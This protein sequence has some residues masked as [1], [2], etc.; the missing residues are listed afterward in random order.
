MRQALEALV[1]VFFLLLTVVVLK[2]L[3]QTKTVVYATIT[4]GE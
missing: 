1:L 3:G 4:K 2:E